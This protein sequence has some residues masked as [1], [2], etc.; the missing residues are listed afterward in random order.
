MCVCCV[1]QCVGGR[2]QDSRGWIDASRLLAGWLD[3][4]RCLLGWFG[5]PARPGLSRHSGG[6]KV[7]STDLTMPESAIHPSTLH[8]H[9]SCYY[10]TRL[11]YNKINFYPFNPSVYKKSILEKPIF[12]CA[13]PSALCL[14]PHKYTGTPA[15]LSHPSLLPHYYCLNAPHSTYLT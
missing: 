1:L 6:F 5:E 11:S 12:D 15:S 4:R 9:L 2:G 7:T 13:P 10:C 14:L 3:G 8:K